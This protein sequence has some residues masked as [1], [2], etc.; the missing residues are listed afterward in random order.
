VGDDKLAEQFAA[1]LA[2][3]AAMGKTHNAQQATSNGTA[4]SST[5]LRFVSVTELRNTTPDEPEWLWD[6]YVAISAI[7]LLA[8]KPKGGKS[9]LACALAEAV[10]AS[11][12][13][14][15]GR[16]VRPGRVVYISEEGAITFRAKTTRDTEGISVLVRENA[17]PRPA[18]ALLIY[19]AITEAKRLDACL[20][21]IDSYAFWAQ[22]A[23]GQE[24][25]ASVNQAMLAALVHAT[26]AGLAVILVHHHRKSGGEDGDAVRGSGSIFG[27]VDAL[28]EIEKPE[29]KV[30]P[31]QR[32]LF[33]IGRFPRMPA[34]TIVDLDPATGAWL[35]VGEADSRRDIGHKT[36]RTT[37]RQAI[38]DITPMAGAGITA[39]EIR[40]AVEDDA[41]EIDTALSELLKE[42][43]IGRAGRGVAGHPYLYTRR[44]SPR[45]SPE[46]PPSLGG[47]SGSVSPPDL[48][49]LEGGDGD[50]DT[51]VATGPGDISGETSH[52]E[53]DTPDPGN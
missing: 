34:A 35:V 11:A 24:N 31:T 52:G 53:T 49:P 14:F 9:T 36:R 15:L 33:A 41:R 21:V 42:G 30:P 1:Q 13:S 22:L 5:E 3:E 2:A 50:T 39:K 12:R 51:S 8:G 19:A 48:P 18:W 43:L 40:I 27:A 4:P 32:A 38:L 29:G 47:D 46:S 10:D 16:P 45:V 26:N 7:T 23:E 6:G 20:L 17:W 44:V 37:V 25:D 28:I